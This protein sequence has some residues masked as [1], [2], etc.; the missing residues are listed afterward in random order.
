MNLLYTLFEILFGLTFLAVLLSCAIAWYESANLRPE[1]MQE[2]FAPRNLLRSLGLIVGETILLYLTLLSHP[3]GWLPLTEKPVRK[4]NKTPVLLLH[5]L[6][7]NR[8]CW[9]WLRLR[10]RMAGYRDIFSLNLSVWHDIEILTE[11]IAKK[12]DSLRLETGVD[13]VILIGHSMGGL[14]A[15]NYIQRRGGAEKV[16]L[17]V[18]LGAPNHGSKLAPFALSP[19]A[20]H[21]V[22]GSDFLRGLN[23]AA[24][25]PEVRMVNILSPQDNMVL[26]WRLAELEGSERHELPWIGHNSLLYHPR[27]LRPLLKALREVAP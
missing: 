7:L 5:G 22:P 10:L 11:M 1:L 6:F 26:P 4:T 17:C 8:A 9:W 23:E 3:F 16:K 13:K 20:R 24:M 18:L 2:R 14:L 27:A 25:P 19:L 21:L 15:R 12:V